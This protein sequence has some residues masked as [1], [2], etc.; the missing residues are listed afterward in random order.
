MLA[1][2]ALLQ[3]SCAGDEVTLS[4]S[5]AR[6]AFVV[7]GITAPNDL[8][9]IVV[10]LTLTNDSDESLRLS[11]GAFSLRMANGIEAQ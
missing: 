3:S 6:Q 4:A 9:F 8:P 7:S 10:D 2:G 11:A 1:V 5:R